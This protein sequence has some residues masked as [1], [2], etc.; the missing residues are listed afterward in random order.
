M[1]LR[2]RFVAR[3]LQQPASMHSGNGVENP[4]RAL[5]CPRDGVIDER[6]VARFL[7]GEF[8]Y[9]AVARPDLEGLDV[10]NDVGRIALR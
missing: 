7:H 10:V 4:D 5:V 1:A 8:E 9:G 2:I 6:I 3:M